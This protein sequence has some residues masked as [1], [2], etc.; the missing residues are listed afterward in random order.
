MGGQP[1]ASVETG[2]LSVAPRRPVLEV[3]VAPVAR[4]VAA[5]APVITV[6]PG[7]RGVVDGGPWRAGVRWRRAVSGRCF[8]VWGLAAP[9]A[10]PGAPNPES[11]VG[12]WAGA[13]AGCEA[14]P[15][16]GLAVGLPATGS[17]RGAAYQAERPG[18]SGPVAWALSSENRTGSPERRGPFCVLQQSF[19]VAGKRVCQ[20]AWAIAVVAGGSRVQRC[21]LQGLHDGESGSGTKAGVL[22]CA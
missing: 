6:G 18:S 8:R 4:V 13:W 10:A 3:I 21:F 5:M 20:W 7:P 11:S 2:L 17:P 1:R 19:L 9:G 16:N 14:G 15:R 12:P 22:S